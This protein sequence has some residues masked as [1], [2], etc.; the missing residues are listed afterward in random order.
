[1]NF[2]FYVEKLRNLDNYKKFIKEFP[3]AYPC[4]CFFVIDK[5]G[6]N[7]KQHFDYYVPKDNKM[8]SFQLELGNFVPV[9]RIGKEIPDKIDLDLNLDF[10]KIEEIIQERMIKEK[11][12]NKIQRFLFSLQ[13]KDQKFYL[14]GTIFI[15]GLGMLRVA[16][17]LGEMKIT[18]FEKKSFF[19]IMKIKRKKD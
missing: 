2:Q 19:D 18:D 12:K 15:S 17:E 7:S 9:E 11:I 6:Q 1:M 8:F 3:K 14:I 4:S 10:N 13:K 16:I 5:G